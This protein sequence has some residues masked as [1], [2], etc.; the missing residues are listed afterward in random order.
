MN[1]F[2]LARTLFVAVIA[3]TAG[4]LQ[5]LSSLGLD[6]AAGVALNV[7]L[8]VAL[9]LLVIVFEHWLK[10]VAATTALG[11]LLG[12]TTGLVIA[13]TIETA[14]T[15]TDSRDPRIVFLRSVGPTS[16]RSSVPGR[17]SGWSR[18]V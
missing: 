13:R 9:A 18:R 15:W 6:G 16:A 10:D 4:L 1:W 17:A 11:A 2:I 8:G 12:G 7:V 3:F 5:P 14:A